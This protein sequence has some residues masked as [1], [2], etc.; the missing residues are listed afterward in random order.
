MRNLFKIFLLI[1]IATVANISYAQESKIKVDLISYWRMRDW[2]QITKTTSQYTE[3]QT[4]DKR[5]V[6]NKISNKSFEYRVLPS[7]R[8]ILRTVAVD[9]ANLCVL[10]K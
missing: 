8:F 3:D 5:L 4:L 1:A 10:M 6:L 9:D 7:D 2:N